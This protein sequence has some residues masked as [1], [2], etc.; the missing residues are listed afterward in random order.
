MVQLPW[1]IVAYE[2]RTLAPN[3]KSDRPRETRHSNMEKG[4]IE[5][6]PSS[7]LRW[8]EAFFPADADRFR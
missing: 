5:K 3:G 2:A 8:G 6:R 1:M 4:P 7:Q